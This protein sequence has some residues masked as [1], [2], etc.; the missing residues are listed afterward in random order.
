MKIKNHLENIY[1]DLADALAKERIHEAY[2]TKLNNISN[3]S[4]RYILE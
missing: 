1:N 3:S 2:N 4:I